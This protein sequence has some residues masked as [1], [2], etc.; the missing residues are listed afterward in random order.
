MIA[1]PSVRPSAA[2][3]ATLCL[4]LL[5][6]SFVC[7]P[8]RAEKD[9]KPTAVDDANKEAAAKPTEAELKTQSRDNVKVIML[10]LH[11][12]HDK[13]GAFPP[14]VLYGKDNTG[15]KFPHSWRVAILPYIDQQKLYNSYH[16]DEAWD[17]PA[18]VE[19]MAK[20]PDVYR[21][22]G[23]ERKSM[24]PAFVVLVGKLMENDS[25]PAKLQTMF[26]SKQGVKM[27]MI[28]DGLSNTLA[29]VETKLEGKQAIQWTEPKDLTYDPAGELPKLGG[30]YAD[31]FW[32]GEADGAA[33][34]I[35]SKTKAA[36]IKGLISPA[37]GE[38]NDL[39]NQ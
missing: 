7:V 14:S 5:A 9:A 19:V 11:N 16:F 10:A 24:H 1:N 32:M 39:F 18:N 8:V 29:I 20:M 25:D 3:A 15:G 23:E 22:P 34:F 17:S 2:L 38:V 36:T 31:G 26:S 28:R 12:Y 35:N 4:S 13:H 37:G 21:A 6:I 33:I 27:Q 30:L